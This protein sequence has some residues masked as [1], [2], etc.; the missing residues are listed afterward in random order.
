[1]EISLIYEWT[2]GEETEIY[3]DSRKLVLK[4][5]RFIT[6]IDLSSPENIETIDLIHYS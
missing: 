2:P 4:R 1:M 5:F 6:V 3:Y